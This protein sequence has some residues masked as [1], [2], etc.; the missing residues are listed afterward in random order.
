MSLARVNRGI[1][2]WWIARWGTAFSVRMY[3][4]ETRIRGV[5]LR[6]AA[7][8]ILFSWLLLL[9]AAVGFPIVLLFDRVAP[10]TGS[11]G[12]SIQYQLTQSVASTIAEGYLVRLL[13]LMLGL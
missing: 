6:M 12:G 9:L 11:V 10:W 13:P 8:L 7:R 5:N 1:A 3:F 2:D 4:D